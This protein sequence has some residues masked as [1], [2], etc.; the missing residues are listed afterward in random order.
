MYRGL[1]IRFI[2]NM[3]Y[4]ANYVYKREYLLLVVGIFEMKLDDF[5]H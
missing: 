1:Q 4:S 2:Q 5:Y 3:A